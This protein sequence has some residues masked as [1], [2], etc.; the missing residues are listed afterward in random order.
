MPR[1]RYTSP[2]PQ[3]PFRAGMPLLPVTLTSQFGIIKANGLVDSGAMI[4]VLPYDLGAQLRLSS[5]QPAISIYIGGGFANLPARI[6]V[7]MGQV[8]ECAPVKMVFA[9]TQ[10]P[11]RQPPLI[12]GQINF[13]RAFQ[14]TLNGLEGWFDVQPIG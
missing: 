2:E 7:V 11:Q 10:D 13:F 12:F 14:V 6:V 3:L 8:G 5:T 1:F 4:N 9:W